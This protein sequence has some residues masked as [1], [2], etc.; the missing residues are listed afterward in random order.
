MYRKVIIM[1]FL[2][3]MT[4]VTAEENGAS[5]K[6]DDVE[7]NQKSVTPQDIESILTLTD[8]SFEHTTQASTGQTTGSWLV[9]FYNST[10]DTTTTTDTTTTHTT[11]P[12]RGTF[13][14]T[15][16]WM[17]RHILVAKVDIATDGYKTKQRFFRKSDPMPS[18]LFVHQGKMYVVPVAKHPPPTH[19]DWDV[20]FKFCV[21][22]PTILALPIPDPP[23]MLDDFI[24]KLAASPTLFSGVAVMIMVLGAFIGTMI[25]M[26]GN[27]IKK[28]KT[29]KTQEITKKQN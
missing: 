26:I 12:F 2:M 19:Y 8:E 28:K 20:I 27:Y 25:E 15:E 13:P 1:A 6:S 22:P 4:T 14:T 11:V 7:A 21:A 3:I 9:W 24:A 18:L 10:V 5:A 16:E 17:E 29:T 23:T